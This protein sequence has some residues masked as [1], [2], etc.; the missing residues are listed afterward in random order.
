MANLWR[1]INFAKDAELWARYII[2][3]AVFAVAILFLLPSLAGMIV[4]HW[5]SHLAARIAY[6]QHK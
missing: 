4:G 3:S 5:L 1:A 6:G 2:G